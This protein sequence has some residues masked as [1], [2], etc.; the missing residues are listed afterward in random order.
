MVE[1]HL[2]IFVKAPRIGAVKTRLAKEI[3]NL[4][5]WQF[6]RRTTNVLLRQLSG[7][8]WRIWLAVTP[9]EFS[10]QHCFWPADLEHLPQGR[11]DLGQR[12]ARPF[13]S[14]PPGPVLVVGSDIPDITRPL[15]E[16]AF[17]ALSKTDV[18]VGP[19]SDGGY[20]LIGMRRRPAPA[21]R[22]FRHV[23]WSSEHA[24]VDTMASLDRRLTVAQIDT[25]NDIDTLAD[26]W[27]WRN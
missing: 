23:R 21:F 11:G 22:L 10:G 18:V 12:M 9:D 13:Y 20:W 3:G 7:G 6:Y 17:N 19:A 16:K 27:E 14:L 8:R 4:A 24:L 25:L 2:V 15:I 1:R 26:Y 5:A